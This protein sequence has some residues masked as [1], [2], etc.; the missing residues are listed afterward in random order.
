MSA[1]CERAP[2][3]IGAIMRDM[4]GNILDMLDLE[5]LVVEKV[6][7]CV[8]IL[9]PVGYG[10]RRSLPCLHCNPEVV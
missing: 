10:G 3:Y 2:P 6:S 7:R 8:S 1:I 4:K 5:E 9:P